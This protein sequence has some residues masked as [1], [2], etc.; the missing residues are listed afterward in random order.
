MRTVRLTEPKGIESVWHL[1]V[2]QESVHFY[3]AAQASRFELVVV[4]EDGKQT[5]VGVVDYGCYT[6]H[7]GHIDYGYLKSKLNL[8]SLSDAHN[9]SALLNA[10]GSSSSPELYNYLRNLDLEEGR[11]CLNHNF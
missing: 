5:V 4:P 9:L 2:E 3:F 6:F 11:D 1:L 10:L 8:P 7:F